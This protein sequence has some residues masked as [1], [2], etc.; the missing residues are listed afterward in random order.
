MTLH[1]ETATRR[2]LVN[3]NYGICSQ[4]SAMCLRPSGLN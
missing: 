4:C 2:R 3:S 1:T